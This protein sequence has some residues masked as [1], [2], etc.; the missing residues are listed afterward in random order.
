MSITLFSQGAAGEVTGSRHFLCVND[1]KILIDCG[2]FQ[3]KREESDRK[4]R[5]WDFN[6]EEL[7]AVVLTHAHFDH[8]GLLPLLPKHDFKGN[9]YSTSA[10]RDL[11][12]IIMLDS[13]KIQAADA[14]H[15][16]KR[17]ARMGEKF[18]W[19]PLYDDIDVVDVISQFVTISYNRPQII[20]DGVKVQFTDAGH[21][22]GSSLAHFTIKDGDKTVRILYSGDI[23]RNDEPILNDPQPA[24]PAEYIVLES[25]YGDRLHETKDEI[26]PALA[27]IVNDTIARGGNVVIPAFA[28]GRTQELV[29][30]L[31][32]LRDQNLI[33]SVPIFIDSPMAVNATAIYKLHPECYDQG[34]HDA[35]TIHHKN[36]FGFNEVRY[37]NSVEE[38]KAI[39]ELK[40]PAIIIS[41]SGM[42]ESGR[43]LHHL[44]NNISDPKNTILLVGYMAAYTLGRRIK[45]GEKQVRIFGDTYTMRAQVE[46]IKALSGHAD[47]KE[48]LAYL[49]SMDL[50]ALKKIFLVHGDPDSLITFKKYLMD[51][52]FN[53]VEIVERNKQYILD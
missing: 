47:Y 40:T 44:I 31:H 4:N 41:A 45:D 33:P 19:K 10:T 2:A 50:S 8:C 17:A 39:S 36:P 21:I 49:K 24:P 29:F 16:A 34:I 23:G 52:G 37:T 51:N 46:E 26:L 38:S 11:A 12:N 3:G 6:A 35:F 27:K 32:L 7:D 28:V 42:C 5:Q 13:A 22:L 53:N 14:V 9:I 18:D 43:I 1:K 30:Y 48:L 25:T 20:A 15:L